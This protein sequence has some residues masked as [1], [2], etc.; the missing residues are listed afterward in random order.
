MTNSTQKMANSTANFDDL[1]AEMISEI[2][3]HLNFNDLISCKQVCRRF[4]EIVGELRIRCLHVRYPEEAE[5]YSSEFC[6]PNLFKIQ[7]AQPIL[8][9]LRSLTIAHSFDLDLNILNQFGE[10]VQLRIGYIRHD[11]PKLVLSLPKL[12]ILEFFEEAG[13]KVTV[14]CLNL[15]RLFCFGW[16]LDSEFA[17]KHPETIHTLQTDFHDRSLQPFKN[18]EYLSCRRNYKIFD[19]STLLALPKLKEI[20]YSGHFG[21][22]HQRSYGGHQWQNVLARLRRF[23]ESKRTL[24]KFDLRVF[25]GCV[26]LVNDKPI[27]EYEFEQYHANAE[28]FYMINYPQLLK[29]DALEVNYSR[30]MDIL[31]NDQIP[32][33]YFD[34]FSHISTVKVDERQGKRIDQEHLLWF[35]KSLKTG[36]FIQSTSLIWKSIYG[37]HS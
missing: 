37:I 4:C 29:T 21:E 32:D 22:F 33:D 3:H 18:V 15:E 5:A 1:P 7:V 34:K 13:C 23:M 14:D 31:G 19:E 17:V 36:A 30:L 35:L 27:N 8:S 26:E 12:R 20:R 16:Y 9:R 6:H 10:L 25:F 11:Q 28:R 2:F 24:E